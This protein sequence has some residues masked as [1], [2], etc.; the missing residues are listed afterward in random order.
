MQINKPR[1]GLPKLASVQDQLLLCTYS[2]LVS[3]SVSSLPA[4]GSRPD[5]PNTA[6]PRAHT[7]EYLPNGR[8]LCGFPVRPRPHPTRANCHRRVR[9]V[10]VN[11][12]LARTLHLTASP[13]SPS[14]V[15]QPS[16]PRHSLSV[17]HTC[18]KTPS[19]PVCILTYT[20]REL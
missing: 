7:G 2:Q 18:N 17:L 14:L 19:A 10:A 9:T 13:T 12:T 5:T 8:A 3:K 6:H 11:P 4:S 20:H 16:S 1:A 15:T